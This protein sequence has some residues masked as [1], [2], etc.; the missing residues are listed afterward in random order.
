MHC[1]SHTSQGETKYYYI[2]AVISPVP[3]FDRLV[4]S[5]KSFVLCNNL[6]N[7]TSREIE[8]AKVTYVSSNYTSTHEMSVSHGN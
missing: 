1:L 6:Y 2:A 5:R 3:R 8:T 7:M 4:Y